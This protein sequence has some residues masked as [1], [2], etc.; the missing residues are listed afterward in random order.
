MAGL[1]AGQLGIGHDRY[2][3]RLP[4]MADRA[5]DAVVALFGPHYSEVPHRPSDYAGRSHT[6]RGCPVGGGARSTGS[7]VGAGLASGR[8]SRLDT[9]AR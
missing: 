8:A 3:W 2:L 4:P 5:D 7:M 6:D 1:M 9:T